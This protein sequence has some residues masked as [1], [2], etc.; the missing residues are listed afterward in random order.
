MAD[1]APLLQAIAKIGGQEL[2]HEEQDDGSVNL[3]KTIKRGKVCV[4]AVPPEDFTVAQETVSLRDTTYCAM[5]DRPR[6]QD[7]IARG[8]DPD[9]ARE[10]KSYNQRNDTV[11]QARD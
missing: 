4:R 6:V 8:V 1:G 9:K 11:E 10:L 7:L 2:G 3:N 5:R